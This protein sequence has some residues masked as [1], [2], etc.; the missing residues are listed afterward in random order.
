MLW[1]S[2]RELNPQLSVTPRELYHWACW[3][4]C[5]VFHR[6]CLFWQ[7]LLL[8]LHASDVWNPHLIHL[9]NSSWLSVTT[10]MLFHNYVVTVV[11]G[12]C[13]FHSRLGRIDVCLSPCCIAQ[14]AT[15]SLSDFSPSW[16]WEIGLRHLPLSSFCI[17]AKGVATDVTHGNSQIFLRFCLVVDKTLGDQSWWLAG[18][19]KTFGTCSRNHVSFT[20]K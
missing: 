2:R 14:N 8:A 7:L 18:V 15:S 6:W 17:L 19:G 16:Q 5:Q 4:P 20:E 13:P 1:D 11:T 10:E 3:D 9:S 12:R